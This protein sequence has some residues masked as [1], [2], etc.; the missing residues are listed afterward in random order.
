MSEA[1]A[2]RVLAL[3]MHPYMDEATQD[4]DHRGG[5]RLQ[6]LTPGPERR[7]RSEQN[8][9]SSHTVAHFFRQA[10]GRPHPAQVFVGRS[11]LRTILAM[12][13]GPQA[14]M[15]MAPMKSRLPNGAP[16][17]RSRS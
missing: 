9:T 16:F 4:A 11:P 17:M 1:A 6:R 5:A 13:R 10:N 14:F 12:P 15:R 8:R 7:Q 3:P 2:G